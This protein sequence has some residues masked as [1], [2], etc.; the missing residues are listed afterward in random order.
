MKISVI[1]CTLLLAVTSTLAFADSGNSLAGL[2]VG[3]HVGLA[4]ASMTNEDS[5]CWYNCSAY[6]QRTTGL[7][8]GIQIGQNFTSGNLLF[9]Y[10]G[11][12]TLASGVDKKLIYAGDRM[13]TSSEFKSV[14]SLRAKTGL[15]VNDTAISLTYG[16]AWGKFESSFATGPAYGTPSYSNELSGRTLG[17]V[18]GVNIEHAFRNNLIIS[19]DYSRYTFR[20]VAEG[21]YQD[22]GTPDYYSGGYRYNAKY[23]NSVDTARVSASFK[24]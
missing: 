9:G 4:N 22:D 20:D 18:Y 14:F 10:V 6:T 15:L 11:D 3:G 2:Y 5:D 16:P 1:G 7:A 23:V 8:Y 24:F 21:W 13:E 12:F 19:V 17:V